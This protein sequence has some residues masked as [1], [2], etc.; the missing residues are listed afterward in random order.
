MMF[1]SDELIS[2]GILEAIP[3]GYSPDQFCM[4]MST[5]ILG[6]KADLGVTLL[7]VNSRGLWEVLG[8][9]LELYDLGEKLDRQRS[10]VFP[11]LM[12][13]LR[14][15]QARDALSQE[16]CKSIGFG[17]E[18]HMFV[19][20][21]TRPDFGVLIIGSTERLDFSPAGL[22]LLVAVTENWLSRG[23]FRTTQTSPVPQVNIGNSGVML[24]ERQ[25]Q[26]LD[27]LADGKTNTEIGRKLS[28]SASLAKQEV[29]FL[30][31]ALQAKNRL[32]VVVQA[33]RQGILPVDNQR[34]AS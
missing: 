5:Q 31:H 27:L 1:G 13:A 12:E 9:F 10:T 29:A 16:T 7:R 2:A 19:A 14:E 22:K 25:I 6:G 3:H 32:D 20:G 15:G 34:A 28:I 18:G 23:E 21:L 11:S 30:S 33:Q 24:T 17:L 4:A 8:G 26:V